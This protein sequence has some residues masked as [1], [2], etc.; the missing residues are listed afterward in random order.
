MEHP[1]SHRG[2][3]RGG[4]DGDLWP[5]VARHPKSR[6]PPAASGDR[7]V[8]TGRKPT[9]D[10]PPASRAVSGDLCLSGLRRSIHSSGSTTRARRTA[11]VDSHPALPGMRTGMGAELVGARCPQQL[12]RTVNVP[13]AQCRRLSRGC[14]GDKVGEIR[15]RGQA[16]LQRTWVEMRYREFCS[17]AVSELHRLNG[18]ET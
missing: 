6:A 1:T 17:D 5:F 9:S 12:A 16:G 7:A 11:I 4:D 10:G 13:A 2:C 15:N 3:F 8:L 14:A 18:V